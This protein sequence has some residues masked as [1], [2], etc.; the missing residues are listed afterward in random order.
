MF[1]Y[2]DIVLWAIMERICWVKTNSAFSAFKS[3]HHLSQSFEAL[4]PKVEN[5]VKYQG[6]GNGL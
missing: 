2:C 3:D 6:M 1:G 4:E 5:I